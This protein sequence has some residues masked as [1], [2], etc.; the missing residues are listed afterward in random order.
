MCGSCECKRVWLCWDFWPKPEMASFAQL[1]HEE[2]VTQEAG[3][4][5]IQ[6][7]SQ[8]PAHIRSVSPSK[9]PRTFP[10]AAPVTILTGI[11]LRHFGQAW[12]TSSRGISP[13]RRFIAA[14]AT[15]PG[16]CL[17]VAAGDT[18]STRPPHPATAAT[19]WHGRLRVHE[20]SENSVRLPRSMIVGSALEESGSWAWE[21]IERRRWSL[22]RRG[23]WARI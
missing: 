16:F 12:A 15:P 18:A 1:L 13:L 10:L 4:G 8:R 11:G 17:P 5:R 3:L 19:S 7:L 22:A 2:L 21:A 23:S 9:T 6:R 14:F 20:T